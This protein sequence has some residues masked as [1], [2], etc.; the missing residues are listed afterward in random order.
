V[1]TTQDTS[2]AIQPELLHGESILWSGKPDTKIVFHKEDLYL[3]PFSLLW[4][5]FAMFWEAAVAG[6]FA[7]SAWLFG[8]VWGIPFVLVG[9]Y[10]IWGRFFYA[11]WKKRRTYYAVTNRRVIVVQN[12][13]R[14]RMA[15]SYLDS[16]PMLIKEESSRGRG[17]LRF[18]PRE[19]MWS[20]RR[21]W[22]IW[23]GITVEEVPTF[24]DIEDVDRIY[25]LVSD[26]REK[27]R[28]TRVTA[29]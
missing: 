9:Q 26:A 17:T 24:R 18:A 25:R 5:G 11:A 28:S 8:M 16:L 29:F 21:G 19:P 22:G 10:L 1:L 14:R 13:W 2:D 3:I 27:A 6:S 12:G 4:G 23:D 7:K 15:A 20:G